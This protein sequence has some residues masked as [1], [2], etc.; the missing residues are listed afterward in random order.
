MNLAYNDD[1][2]VSHFDT[3]EEIRVEARNF[4][5]ERV[6]VEIPERIN[7][8]WE[9]LDS[10]EKFEQKD[11][12]TIQYTL[13]VAPGEVKTITYRVRHLGR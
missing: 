13:D 7:G 2:D 6:R 3:E 4:R 11:A 5:P 1:G 8:Q 12:N 9:M 10:T